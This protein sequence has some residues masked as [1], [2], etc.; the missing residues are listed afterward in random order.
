MNWKSI[1][2][3]LLTAFLTYSCIKSPTLIDG[4]I[5][6]ALGC[7]YGLEM[8]LAW[9]STPVKQDEELTKL[10]KELEIDRLTF[11]K[12]RISRAR[13]SETEQNSGSN[14]RGMIKF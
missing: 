7:L 2:L 8:F 5:I 9:K 10:R 3:W 13:V 11:E 12:E 1:P 14:L 6:T 4:L